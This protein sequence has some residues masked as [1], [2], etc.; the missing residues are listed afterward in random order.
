MNSRARRTQRRAD[1]R[2]AATV[3]RRELYELQ[4]SYRPKRKI[5]NDVQSKVTSNEP[6]P[7][8]NSEINSSAGMKSG[9]QSSA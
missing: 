6:G 9:T 3:R 5:K 7:A 4:R 2:R 8:A 1:E